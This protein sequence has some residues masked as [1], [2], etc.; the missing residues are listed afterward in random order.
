MIFQICN[1]SG[2]AHPPRCLLT[3]VDPEHEEIHLAQDP[4]ERSEHD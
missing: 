1:A 3:K 4:I 2:P